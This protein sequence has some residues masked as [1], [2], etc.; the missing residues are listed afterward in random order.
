MPADDSGEHLL[1]FAG[2]HKVGA[3]GDVHNGLAQCFVHGQLARPETTNAGLIPQRLVQRLPQ[4]NA[5]VLHGVVRI[6]VDVTVGVHRQVEAA[7]RA[8]GGEHVVKER[9]PRVDVSAPRAV[10]VDAHGDAGFP[11]GALHASDAGVAFYLRHG[12]PTFLLFHVDGRYLS[13]CC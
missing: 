7:V 2:D 12:W 6:N 8:E 4:H 13:S 1:R 3:A 9:Q 5:R 11:G 10:Q